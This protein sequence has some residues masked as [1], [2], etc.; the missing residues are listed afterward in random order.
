MHRTG[1]RI[2]AP[3]HRRDFR[4]AY[5]CASDRIGAVVGGSHGDGLTRLEPLAGRHRS[6]RMTRGR[7]GHGNRLRAAHLNVRVVT[8]GQHSV[9]PWTYCPVFVEHRGYRLCP[10]DE[11]KA[12]CNREVGDAGRHAEQPWPAPGQLRVDRRQMTLQ[13]C[14]AVCQCRAW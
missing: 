7:R 13:L 10:A 8:D 11:P 1:A 6:W 14:S 2:D 3:D 12:M 5:K 9:K 4:K